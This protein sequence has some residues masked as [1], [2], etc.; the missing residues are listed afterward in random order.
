M[1]WRQA[2]RAR[3]GRTISGSFDCRD[4]S[5]HRRDAETLREAWLRSMG[6]SAEPAEI[7]EREYLVR[8]F[9]YLSGLERF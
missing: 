6:A 8:N 2:D 9:G 1:S 4:G 3:R 5:L 7:A